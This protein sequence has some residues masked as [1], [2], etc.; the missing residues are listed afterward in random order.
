MLILGITSFTLEIFSALLVCQIVL[1]WED[2]EKTKG[3]KP[4]II[5]IMLHAIIFEPII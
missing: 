2:E 1:G 5:E 4:F 3:M